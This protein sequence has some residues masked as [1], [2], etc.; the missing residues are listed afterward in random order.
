MEPHLWEQLVEE[1]LRKLPALEG[2][3]D[4]KCHLSPHVCDL[5]SGPCTTENGHNH[6][7]NHHHNL[8]DSLLGHSIF[9]CTLYLGLGKDRIYLDCDSDVA[10]I[11][12]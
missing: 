5:D 9:V 11:T 10:N 3:V 8:C 1:N 4:E 7:H 12:Q 6:N 2:G